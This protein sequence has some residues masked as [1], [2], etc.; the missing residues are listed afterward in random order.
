MHICLYSSKEILEE[1]LC[2]AHANPLYKTFS[3]F[4]FKSFLV[5]LQ[6]S[7]TMYISLENFVV[8]M[9][10]QFVGTLPV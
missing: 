8:S 1:L 3:S 5:T 9:A 6:V 10:Q 2:F 7:L 4:V